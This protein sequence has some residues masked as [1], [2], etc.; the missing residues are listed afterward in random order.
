MDS[1][2]STSRCFVL[3]RLYSTADLD[4][5]SLQLAA[6]GLGECSL[7]YQLCFIHTTTRFA[8]SMPIEDDAIIL[9]KE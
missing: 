9:L 2:Q 7:E 6:N 5:G 8:D 4:V 1:K 3:A